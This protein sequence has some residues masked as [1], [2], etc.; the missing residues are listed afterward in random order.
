[1]KRTLTVLAIAAAMIAFV[2]C[3]KRS[4][5]EVKEVKPEATIA[6]PTGNYADKQDIGI[7]KVATTTDE[8]KAALAGMKEE[9]NRLSGIELNILNG[10][11]EVFLYQGK[12]ASLTDRAVTARFQAIQSAMAKLDPEIEKMEKELIDFK[13]TFIRL[14]VSQ[15]S[16]GNYKVSDLVVRTD[17]DQP[18]YARRSDDGS[19]VYHNGKPIIFMKDSKLE[20]KNIPAGSFVFDGAEL[21]DGGKINYNA[22]DGSLQFAM[23]QKGGVKYTFKGRV[24]PKEEGHAVIS[25]NMEVT[26]DSCDHVLQTEQWS[27]SLPAVEEPL[28]LNEEVKK[29]AVEASAPSSEKGEEPKTEKKA[30]RFGPF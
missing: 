17:K 24:E 18:D 4:P 25:G 27:V 30:E 22:L 29:E 8:D 13:I 20:H 28:P 10:I 15:E 9:R 23:L 6:L 16:E 2:A 26:C 3:G 14:S 1:M 21:A 11:D 5:E 7:F 12:T 19:I